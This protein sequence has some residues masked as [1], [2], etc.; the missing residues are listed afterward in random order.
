MP[1]AL[2]IAGSDS[3]GG[4]GVQADLKTFQAFGVFGTS[5][6]TAV[7]AQNTVGVHAVH[8]VPVALVQAQIDAVATDLPPA[9]L[10]TGMLATEELVGAVAQRIEAH[11]L[12]NFVLDPV[13]VSTSGHP[14][15]ERGARGAVL[16]LLVPAARLVT[17]NIPEAELLTGRTV[18]SGADMLDAARELV[19]RGARA[20]LIKGGHLEGDA[21]IDLLWDGEQVHRWVRARVATKHTHGTGCTLSAAACAGLARGDSLVP[22]V[23]RALDYVAAAIARAPGLGAGHGPLDFGPPAGRT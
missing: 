2:T 3:G 14:L 1:I 15:L 23:A 9:A 17:P 10:K 20:A 16:D 21:L 12:K 8:P 5:A 4:A 7:T 13:M 22:A 6:I 19:A 11:G 18:T